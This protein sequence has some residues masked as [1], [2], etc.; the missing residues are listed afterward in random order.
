MK[1]N[2]QRILLS[3][4]L[5]FGIIFVSAFVSEAASTLG[6]YQYPALRGE[7]LVFSAEGDIWRVDVQGGTARRLT[8]HPG[9]ETHPAVSPDGQ[10]LAFSATYEGP[11]EVYTMPIAGGVPT[12][13]TYESDSS[14]VVGFTPDGRLIYTT[15]AY[16]TLPNQQLVAIDLKTNKREVI[17]LHQAGDGSYDDSSRALYFVRPAFHNNNTQRYEGG[18]A[19]NIWKF[20][21]GQ[22]EARNLTADFPGENFSPMWW[23]GRVY[24]V[25]ER[26]GTWNIWSMDEEGRDL[27]QH[28]R[29]EGWNV[30]SPCL[31]NGRIVYQLGADLRALDVRSGEDQLIPI[32]LA[33]DFDQLRE[34]WVKE[35]LDYLTSAHVHPGGES[36]VLT[37]RG[38]VFVAPV[39]DGRLVRA[40]FKEG[41]RYRD[42]VFMPGGQTLL[43]LSDES[44][45]L[46]FVTMPANGVGEEKPLTHD[47]EILRFQ[48]HPSPDGKWVAYDDKNNDLWLLNTESKKQTKISLSQ[49]GTGDI[50]W[51]PDS[52]WLAFCE[53]AFNTFVQIHLYS[54]ETGEHIPLTTDRVNSMS[55]AWSPDG[56]FIYFLSDRNLQSVVSSPWG[57]RQ[58]EPYFDKPMKIYCLSLQQ[59]VRSPFKPEDELYEPPETRDKQE[60]SAAKEVSIQ[61]DRENIQRRIREVPVEP[62]KLAGLE[63]NDRALFWIERGESYRDPSRLKA[64]KIGN[65]DIKAVTVLEGI[66]NFEMTPNGEKIMLREG[67]SFYVLDAV[68][69]KIPDLK[70]GEVNLQG[71]SYPIDVREDLRQLYIDAWRLERDYFWDPGMH[72]VDW[73]AMRDKYLPLVDR[74]TTR[75]ELN[76]LIGELVG[77]LSALHVSVRGGDLRE[78]PD[79]IRVATLGARLQRDESAGGYRISYIYKSD[80][81]Y[82][83]EL[84]PLADPDLNVRAG[85]VITGINGQSTLSVRHPRALLRNQAG[86]QVLV[87]VKSGETGETRQLI[88]APTENEY[89]LRYNDWQYTRRMEVEEKGEGEIGYVHLRAMGGGNITE[90][91]RNF[92]PVFKRKGLIIDVRNNRGGN[93]DAF[94]LGK[95]IR[96]AWFYWKPRAGN[97]YWNMHYAFRGHMVVLCDENT[98][99]D[100][101]AFAEGFKRLGLGKVIGTRTWGGEIWLSSNN[102]LTDR[103]LARAPQTGV[104]GPEREWLIEGHGVDPDIVVDNL[105]HAT[106][107][108]KDAQLEAAVDYLQEQIRKH[109]VDIPEPPP[110]PDKSFKTNTKK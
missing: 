58:P 80:P 73:E 102:R 99:S 54:V 11:T 103:G 85:D 27:K 92:Y 7:T 9:E 28:T 26:D 15:R 49:E 43:A 96:K 60:E 10:I 2:K 83:G 45:E 101:E 35:P 67:N 104:Y 53:T 1:N 25:S 14:I 42:A 61:I 82:P 86:Q 36:V 62:G 95:L 109:P 19:Q 72:G 32:S 68:P 33:S 76:D 41:I 4:C 57:T 63:V 24:Y 8:T 37:S 66:R 98:A 87:T 46:E 21:D 50:S 12:R 88:I 38:R 17:P 106:F 6:Y 22:T 90:W 70:K 52:K 91:Y 5:F 16:S 78:G 107:K 18:T 29:H 47:G 48:G 13:W 20:T 44:G 3:F 64:V 31:D 94:I 77:E 74:I 108:G 69:K 97:P 55:P 39:G 79:Q 51:S 59:G 89:N 71:W 100:G 110:Y 65:E 30:K 40:S 93:I 105:P 56:R 34:K 75:R 23:N 84:S 81:D